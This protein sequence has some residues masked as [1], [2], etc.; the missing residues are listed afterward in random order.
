MPLFIGSSVHYC[1][2]SLYE[3]MQGIDNRNN[4]AIY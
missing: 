1:T 4:T 2:L 3:E